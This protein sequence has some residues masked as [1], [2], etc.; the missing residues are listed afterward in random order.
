M[1]KRFIPVVAADL[2]RGP[3]LNEELHGRRV[4]VA[5]DSNQKWCLTIQ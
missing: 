4:Q 3:L 5:C 1:C 2:I